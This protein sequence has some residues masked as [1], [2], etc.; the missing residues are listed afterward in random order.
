M[1]KM[2]ENMAKI[3]IIALMGALVF[4]GVREGQKVADEHTRALNAHVLEHWSDPEF[5]GHNCE[6][7]DFCTRSYY[8]WLKE[9][10]KK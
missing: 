4:V 3:G 1:K 10:S 5:K 2:I 7:G 6:Y 9:R 8:D